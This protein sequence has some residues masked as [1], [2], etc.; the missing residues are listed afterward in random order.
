M[1]THRVCYHFACS[2]NQNYHSILSQVVTNPKSFPQHFLSLQENRVFLSSVFILSCVH[3][4]GIIAV[5]NKCIQEYL[6]IGQLSPSWHDSGL[7]VLHG[8]QTICATLFAFNK[9][10]LALRI[11]MG[12]IELLSFMEKKKNT[13]WFI[14]DEQ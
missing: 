8:Q 10:L 11:N 14:S 7:F 2:L 6:I 9:C 12:A 4:I 13:T 1:K 5:N 3:I